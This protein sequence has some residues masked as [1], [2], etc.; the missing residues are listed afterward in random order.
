[1]QNSLNPPTSGTTCG[2][3]TPICSKLHRPHPSPSAVLIPT[4]A[5]LYNT[6]ISSSLNAIS[7][8]LI[9]RR[10]PNCSIGTPRSVNS[11]IKTS[12]SHQPPFSPLSEIDSRIIGFVGYFVTSST[13]AIMR[14]SRH[15]R[16]WLRL[17]FIMTKASSGILS[18][19]RA[20][21]RGIGKNNFGSKP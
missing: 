14:I 5:I 8:L 11:L 15:L 17:R 1:M 18:D 19:L 4:S 3:P 16:G 7:W 13:N 2:T 12:N 10:L 6:L 20:R 21:S 9:I